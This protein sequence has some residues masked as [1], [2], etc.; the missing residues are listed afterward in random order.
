MVFFPTIFNLKYEIE[1]EE[2]RDHKGIKGNLYIVDHRE[3]PC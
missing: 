3:N 2:I 1:G